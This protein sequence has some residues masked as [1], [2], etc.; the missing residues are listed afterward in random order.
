MNEGVALFPQNE[1]VRLDEEAM[2]LTS[3]IR[4]KILGDIQ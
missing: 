1:L 2:C 4:Y 3:M